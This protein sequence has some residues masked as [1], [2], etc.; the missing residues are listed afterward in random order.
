MSNEI[1]TKIEE[2]H[3]QGDHWSGEEGYKVT[4][5]EQEVLLLIDNAQSCCEDWGYLMSEDEPQRFVGSTL[6]GIE[7]TETDRT[8]KD[9]V[10]NMY[11]GD[12]LFVDLKTSMGTLQFVAYNY[13]NG[14]YGHGV[15][16]ES[17]QLKHS[18]VL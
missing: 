6:L 11:E 12:V 10:E 7:I 2:V 1:I 13:H 3:L 9:L 4:T 14:Y 8:G 16:V 5:S 18:A 15:R 17:T